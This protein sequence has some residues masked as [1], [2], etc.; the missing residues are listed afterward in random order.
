MAIRI[1]C[2]II[3]S[4]VFFPEN[5]SATNFFTQAFEYIMKNT[6]SSDNDNNNNGNNQQ[7]RSMAM[8]NGGINN[9]VNHPFFRPQQQAP[10]VNN[11]VMNNGPGVFPMNN[12]PM[13][14]M[15]VIKTACISPDGTRFARIIKNGNQERVIVRMAQNNEQNVFN[16]SESIEKIFFVGANLIVCAI[17]NNNN[18]WYLRAINLLNRTYHNLMPINNATYIDIIPSKNSESICTISY[19]GQRYATHSINLRT[20]QM[21]SI[22]ESNAKPVIDKNLN[23]RIFYKLA[24]SI[25]GTT[26]GFDVFAIPEGGTDINAAQIDHINDFSKET[27]VSVAGNYCYKLVLQDNS[28]VLV[29]YNLADGSSIDAGSISGV[30]SLKNCRINLDA[31]GHPS[32]ITIG[33]GEQMQN[34]P[35]TNDVQAHLQAIERQFGGIGWKRVSSTADNSVWILCACTQPNYRYFIYDTRNG[36]MSEIQVDSRRA[37]IIIQPT[38]TQ[39][40]QAQGVEVS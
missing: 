6:K 17:R 14:N 12:Q 16:T 20:G 2:C 34:F 26:S 8:Q 31:N 27:Y 18:F 33:A 32:F 36:G 19:N 40:T 23:V 9:G 28:L 10:F 13:N 7:Q 15:T 35:L 30:T 21:L 38:S 3:I 24:V 5:L 29:G 37:N 25:L 39:R 4:I 22:A 11:G 1:I